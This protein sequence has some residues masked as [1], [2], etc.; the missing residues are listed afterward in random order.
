MRLF[1]TCIVYT[2]LCNVIV[3]RILKK[4]VFLIIATQVKWKYMLI[5]DAP[6]NLEIELTI[7]TQHHIIL[8][9]EIHT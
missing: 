6:L 5:S 9:S 8:F 4:L 1:I 7:Y 3:E 2:Y